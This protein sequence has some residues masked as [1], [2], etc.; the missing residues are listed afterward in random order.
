MERADP[1]MGGREPAVGS[2]H[3]EASQNH[4]ETGGEQERVRRRLG[5][6]RTGR[7]SRWPPPRGREPRGRRTRRGPRTVPGPPEGRR[8]W[9]ASG[10]GRPT[11][12]EVEVARRL[13]VQA[14]WDFSEARPIQRRS[15]IARSPSKTA[16][17]GRTQVTLTPLRLWVGSQCHRCSHPSRTPACCR[18]CSRTRRCGCRSSG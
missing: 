4:A 1:K 17:F 18:D 15:I 16:S 10:Q 3:P 9:P 8:G 7:G 6:R 14:A 5:C 2:G 11:L 12:A 13:V